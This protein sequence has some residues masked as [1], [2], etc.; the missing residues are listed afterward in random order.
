[1]MRLC[2]HGMLLPLFAVLLLPK[3]MIMIGSELSGCCGIRTSLCQ[4]EHVHSLDI[5]S[6]NFNDSLAKNNLFGSILAPTHCK[7]FIWHRAFWSDVKWKSKSNVSIFIPAKQAWITPAQ[8][9]SYLRALEKDIRILK[10][11]SSNTRPKT[12][13]VIPKNRTFQKETSLP[14]IHFRGLC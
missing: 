13:L 10:K 14:T 5:D 2:C 1:M 9:A 4:H 12:N 7:S 3:Q 6:M 8:Q 11:W